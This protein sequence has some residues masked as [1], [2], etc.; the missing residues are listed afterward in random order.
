MDF[1][2]VTG[3]SSGLGELFARKLAESGRDVVIVARRADRL[4]Q[5]RDEISV[6]QGVRIEA[7]AIDLAAQGS[8]QNL[9]DQLAGRGI[10]VSTLINNAGYGANGS[11]AAMDMAA[12]SRM[13]DLNCRTLMELCHLAL[14]HMIARREG[15]IL[16]VASTAA[17]QPGP[18]MSVYY[19]TKAFVLNFSQG[20][21]EEV[22]D[23]GV[24]VAA[25]CPGPTATEFADVASMA[26]SRLFTHFAMTPEKV[27]SDG[28]A[29]LKSNQA[30]RIS[31]ARNWI[32][33]QSNR[34]APRAMVRQMVGRLQRSRQR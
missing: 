13:I 34:I 9:F 26:D 21:H 30:V 27:V 22:K 1:A 32:M 3:A 8:A 12:Q 29:A 4:E 24:R 16:N 10:A 25:L 33:A 15:G 14:P 23:Q 18:W 2:L 31:G 20:L 17:F 6:R 19:A 11:F 28:L 5:L 7:I